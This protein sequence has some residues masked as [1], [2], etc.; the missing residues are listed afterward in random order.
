MDYWTQIVYSSFYKLD[1]IGNNPNIG[2]WGFT[3]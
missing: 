2:I 1:K 3:T